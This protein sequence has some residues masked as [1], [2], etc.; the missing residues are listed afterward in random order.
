MCQHYSFY[1]IDTRSTELLADLVENLDGNDQ[2]KAALFLENHY[3]E[4]ALLK[5]WLDQKLDKIKRR[6]INL[7]LKQYTTGDKAWQTGLF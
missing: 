2:E 7:R 1:Y 5:H 6:E 3:E 4:I